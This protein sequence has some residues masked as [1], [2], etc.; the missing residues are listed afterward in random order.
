MRMIAGLAGAII[1]LNRFSAGEPAPG[2]SNSLV[3]PQ[4]AR[5]SLQYYATASAGLL[6]NE[7]Y[8][9]KALSIL[10]ESIHTMPLPSIGP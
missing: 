4:V 8:D 3:R 2:Q 7:I 10:T 6:T 5:S 1:T 9:R